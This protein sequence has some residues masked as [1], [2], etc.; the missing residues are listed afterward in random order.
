MIFFSQAG[1]I[2]AIKMAMPTEIGTAMII[3]KAVKDNVLTMNNAAPKRSSS[4]V[5]SK[6][7][8]NSAGDTSRKVKIAVLPIKKITIAKTRH[9][10]KILNRK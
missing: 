4:G 7:K 1:A 10:A 5:Q 9:S 2:S 6:E 3:V 8:K